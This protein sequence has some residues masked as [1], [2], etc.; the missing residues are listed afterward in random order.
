MPRAMTLVARLPVNNSARSI[1]STSRAALA[2]AGALVFPLS[3]DRVGGQPTGEARHAGPQPPRG[4]LRADPRLE[5][6]P[7]A[8]VAHH[9]HQLVLRQD[10]EQLGTRRVRR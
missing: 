9:P 8:L 2:H 1:S 4:E 3:I 7:D 10:A 6:A 5:L